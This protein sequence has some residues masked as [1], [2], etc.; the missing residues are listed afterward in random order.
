MRQPVLLIYTS[1]FRAPTAHQAVCKKLRRA[2]NAL[3]RF[4][5]FFFILI[6]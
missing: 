6:L 5:F 4:S 2:L 1:V 3:Q